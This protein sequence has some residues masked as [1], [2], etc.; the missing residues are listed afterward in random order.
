MLRIG[1][2]FPILWQERLVRDNSL[3]DNSCPHYHYCVILQY[4][5][6]PTLSQTDMQ[7]IQLLSSPPLSL[8][9][10]SQ[11]HTLSASI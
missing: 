7:A 9:G 4:P 6:C 1:A 8:F 3:R 11:E 2:S 10:F 5:S